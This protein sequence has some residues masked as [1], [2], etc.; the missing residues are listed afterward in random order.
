MEGTTIVKGTKTFGA[1]GWNS[2]INKNELSYCVNS[3]CKFKNPWATDMF[4]GEN[5]MSVLCEH[6]KSLVTTK[7]V[8]NKKMKKQELTYGLYMVAKELERCTQV[9]V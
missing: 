2:G 9:K 3:L 1:S 5:T 7:Q 4:K 6:W 8:P